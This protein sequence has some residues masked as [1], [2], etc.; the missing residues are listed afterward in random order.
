[1]SV[2]VHFYTSIRLKHGRKVILSLV[3][4]FVRVCNFLEVKKE[5]LTTH[6]AR[7]REHTR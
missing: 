1:M 5:M 7:G 2:C 4:W 6:P 3:K